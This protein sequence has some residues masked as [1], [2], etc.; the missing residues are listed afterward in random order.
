MQGW[1]DLYLDPIKAEGFL[2]EAKAAAEESRK[3]REESAQQ[4]R[5]AALEL[6]IQTNGSMTGFVH[7]ISNEG[8]ATLPEIVEVVQDLERS[9]HDGQIPA[10]PKLKSS[11][12]GKTRPG[13]NPRKQIN[14]PAQ[15]GQDRPE[16]FK[17]S[18]RRKVGEGVSAKRKGS[19]KDYKDKYES[20]LR[21]NGWEGQGG[22]R[23][24]KNSWKSWETEVKVLFG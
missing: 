7:P 17:E 6:Y 16:G 20:I 5:D 13:N 9:F 21:L 12:S 24:P 8:L 15:E 1:D 14:V 18:K 3:K 11:K 4:R 10:G 23:M 19:L 22:R 2:E